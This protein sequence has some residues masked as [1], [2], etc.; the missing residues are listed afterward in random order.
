M[1]IVGVY[2]IVSKCKPNRVYI[3]SSINMRKRWNLHL[4]HLRKNIHGN[5][6]LQRHYNKHGEDDLVFSIVTLC[7]KKHILKL[8]QEYLDLYKPYFNILIIAGSPLGHH[9]KWSE[10]SKKNF[11][12]KRKGCIQSEKAREKNRMAHLG[13]IQWNKGLSG[14]KEEMKKQYWSNKNKKDGSNS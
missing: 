5:P 11:S 12:E 3:G 10:E 1:K 2:R 9:W 8:E 14:T 13:Q 6:K 4:E 7:K